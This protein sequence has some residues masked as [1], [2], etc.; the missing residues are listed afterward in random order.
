MCDYLS[1]IFF[2]S[3]N[4]HENMSQSCAVYLAVGRG[5]LLFV[6]GIYFAFVMLISAISLSV[7]MLVLCVYHQAPTH[8][9]ATCVPV[10]QWVS[11]Q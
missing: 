7:T 4:R 1:F 3:H 10:P 9:L 2:I 6:V 8:A 5:E 11:I